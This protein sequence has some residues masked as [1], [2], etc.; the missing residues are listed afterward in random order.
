MSSPKQYKMVILNYINEKCYISGKTEV[1]K[2]LLPELK[3]ELEANANG[4]D[5]ASSGESHKVGY[6]TRLC[7]SDYNCNLHFIQLMERLYDNSFSLEACY[8]S[9][10]GSGASSSSDLAGESETSQKNS[11]SKEYIFIKYK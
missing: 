3:L 1:I 6:S 4:E 9:S 8:G 2:E 7:L 5:E 10:L 11:K